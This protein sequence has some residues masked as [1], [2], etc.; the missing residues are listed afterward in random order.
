MCGIILGI[1]GDDKSISKSLLKRYEKQKSR[2]TEG[3]GFIAPTDGRIRS[4]ERFETEKETLASLRTQTSPIIM[5]HHRFPT[6][7]ENWAELNHPIRVAHPTLKYDYYV[8]HNGV[9]SNAVELNEEHEKLGFAYTTLVET[10]TTVKT[11]VKE[12]SAE[13][14]YDFNDSES[15]AIDI[16][17]TLEG[18]QDQMKSKGS[19]AFILFQ[20]NKKGAIQN[21]IY[22]HN[23]R[24][25]LILEVDKANGMMFLKS[26]GKGVDV[27][28]DKIFVQDF[29]THKITKLDIKVGNN[30]EY[31]PSTPSTHTPSIYR[32]Y[33][34]DDYGYGWRGGDDDYPAH[35]FS[36]SHSRTEDDYDVDENGYPTERKGLEGNDEN[37]ESP[38]WDSKVEVT[39]I[40]DDELDAYNKFEKDEYN[41][42]VDKLE[43][44]LADIEDSIQFYVDQIRE[45]KND[46]LN[47]ELAVAEMKILHREKEKVERQLNDLTI[48]FYES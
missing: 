47:R 14:S 20:T 21:I 23:A 33:E 44:E 35:L 6:S 30:W 42:K 40:T 48:E 7:T 36:K 37:I 46:D 34:N 17:L 15:L 26:E 5:F 29:K 45:F 39:P 10:L 32:G 19:I 28:V 38:Y 2:G 25:P 4:V 9:I 43:N 41:R 16:A 24:N 3:F 31:T 22:G 18:K 11:Q 12:R 1:R 8:I 27:E 13:V